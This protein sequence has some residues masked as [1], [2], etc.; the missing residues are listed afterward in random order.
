MDVYTRASFLFGFVGIYFI[1]IKNKRLRICY[2]LFCI[3][4]WLGVWVLNRIG[5]YQPFVDFPQ[6]R[7]ATLRLAS[8]IA[9]GTGMFSLLYENA[10]YTRFFTP[11]ITPFILISMNGKKIKIL[12]KDILFLKA[13][14]NYVEIHMCDGETWVEKT[15]LT[16]FAKR[17]PPYFTQVHKSYWINHN[18]V[19]QYN[20]KSVLLG[21][22]PV[23]IGRKYAASIQK[24]LSYIPK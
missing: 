15:S 4:L 14:R 6:S 1:V 20:G 16:S 2:V 18:K 8:L 19:A 17:L 24:R 3:A 22:L 21:K 23:P 11:T 10:I 12:P 5:D 7:T 9:L 13:A